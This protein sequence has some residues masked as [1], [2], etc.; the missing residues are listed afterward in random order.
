MDYKEEQEQELEVLRS[1]YPEEVEVL[2]GEY[3]RIRFQVDLKLEVVPLERSSFTCDTISKEHHLVLEFQLP[4]RYPEEAPEVKIEPY[5]VS[6]EGGGEEGEGEE[7]EEQEYDDHGNL[8]VGKVENIP[9]L[10]TFNE[11][12]PKLMLDVHRQVEEDMLLGMQMCFA[13]ISSIKELS[14]DW[15]QRKLD[16]L[17]KEHERRLREREL[18]EQKKFRG[19]KVTRES[20]LAWR[21]KFRQELGLEERD[22]ER[23]L[24]A[25]CGRITGR[26]LFEQGLDGEDDA[27]GVGYEEELSQ[28]VRDL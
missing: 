19:T 23:R 3:P 22:A 15:F 20:Y 12:V 24:Q 27:D 9:D 16:S 18:E 21:S 2:C 26:K 4:E 25:H 6:M 8:I 10:I 1:I 13:L 11:Y 5:V 28:A 17:E 14:E 7:E